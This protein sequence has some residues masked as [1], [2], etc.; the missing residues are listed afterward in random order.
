MSMDSTGE[1]SDDSSLVRATWS[2]SDPPLEGALVDTAAPYARV[3]FVFDRGNGRRARHLSELGGRLRPPTFV[4]SRSVGALRFKGRRG[5][6]AIGFRV[7]PIVVSTLLSR[8]PAEIWNEPAALPALV[9]PDIGISSCD[10]Q[11]LFNHVLQNAPLEHLDMMSNQLGWSPKGLRRLFAKSAALSAQ[12]A[13]LIARHLDTCESSRPLPNR[14]IEEQPGLFGHTS[15]VH[16]VWDCI[17]SVA[18]P[19]EGQVVRRPLVARQ[20]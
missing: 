7:S 18:S 12:D 14:G 9:G 6:L 8:P 4:Y 1:D 3:E 2:L 19:I 20:R 15:F 13:Q 16:S 17:D 11:C 10:V 5:T